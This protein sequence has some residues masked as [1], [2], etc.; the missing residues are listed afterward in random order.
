MQKDYRVKKSQEI[1]TIMKNGQSKANAY[2][3]IYKQVNTNFE[4]FRMAIS[5]GK[6]V[7]I[8]VER[9]KI[10]RR[11]RAIT[12][13]HKH[14]MN[15]QYDY[16][17]IARKGVDQLDYVTFKTKLEQLYRKMNMIPRERN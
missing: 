3:I 14:H 10:K 2:F 4:H 11:I 6:K 1:T 5:V 8:A 16:F 12:T 9:N 15:P 7:G 17:I 13:E